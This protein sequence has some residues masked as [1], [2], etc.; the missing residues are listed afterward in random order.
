MKREDIKVGDLIKFKSETNS[1]YVE[2]G[3]VLDI[4]DIVGNR[5]GI[6]YCLPCKMEE[7]DEEGN[8]GYM[9]IDHIIELERFDTLESIKLDM[10]KKS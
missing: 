2:Y 6:K 5:K 7:V 3:L 10:N 8:R 9:P 4:Y 1:K